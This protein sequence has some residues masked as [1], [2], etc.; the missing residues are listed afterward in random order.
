MTT[1]NEQHWRAVILSSPSRP[2][3]RKAL[4]CTFKE[5]KD[6]RATHMPD[7]SWPDLRS[8]EDIAREQFKARERTRAARATLDKCGVVY[9]PDVPEP[10]P[11]ADDVEAAI[12][13][14]NP[15]LMAALEAFLPGISP[16]QM[17]NE[18]H[19]LLELRLLQAPSSRW[20]DNFAF[21]PLGRAVQAKLKA[22][23]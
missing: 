17:K 20:A 14:L 23:Q 3:A 16:K 21:T 6:F 1:I 5:L 22:A 8:A 12:L 2:K 18:Y 13:A 19:R 10:N 15:P 11:T 9:R 7:H 4:G